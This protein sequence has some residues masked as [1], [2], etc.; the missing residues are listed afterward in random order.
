MKSADPWRNPGVPLAPYHYLHS[1]LM[2]LKLVSLFENDP[3]NR[4]EA[5]RYRN[6]NW[7]PVLSHL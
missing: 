4:G 5:G 3:A 6:S 7:A 2:C 1:P